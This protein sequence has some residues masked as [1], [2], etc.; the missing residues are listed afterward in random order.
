MTTDEK[1]D[2]LK[3]WYKGQNKS[4]HYLL[5]ELIFKQKVKHLP[6]ISMAV[7][8]LYDEFVAEGKIKVTS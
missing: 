8:V 1:K 5:E 6:G 7:D 4:L 2:G 3:A